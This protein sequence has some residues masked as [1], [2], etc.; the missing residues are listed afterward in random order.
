MGRKALC[1][2][3]GLALTYSGL[4]LFLSA[5]FQFRVLCFLSKLRLQDRSERDVTAKFSL[6]TFKR[7]VG[8][9]AL[10]KQSECVGMAIELLPFPFPLLSPFSFSR[11]TSESLDW[12]EALAL[13]FSCAIF[14]FQRF[15][16]RKVTH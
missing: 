9:G 15:L 12:N 13:N 8:H 16:L 1:V 11:P 3:F 10:T 6:C 7:P 14:V 4:F 2:A 5:S